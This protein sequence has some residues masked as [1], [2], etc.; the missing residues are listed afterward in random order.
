M[1]IGIVLPV[2]NGAHL[3]QKALDS[4]VNQTFFKKGNYYIIYLV[5]ND[6]S[7]DLVEKIKKYKNINYIK[8]NSVLARPLM[9]AC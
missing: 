8:S 3:I 7:Y 9:L 6:S 4:V 5:D 2:R 1:K